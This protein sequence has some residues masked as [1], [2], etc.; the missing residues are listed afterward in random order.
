MKSYT[1]KGSESGEEKSLSEAAHEKEIEAAHEKEI[2][3]AR[4]VIVWM[5]IFAKMV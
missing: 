5:G 3:A 1:L 2:E 4:T